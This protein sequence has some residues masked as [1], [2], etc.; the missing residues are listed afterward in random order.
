MLC[1]DTYYIYMF[2]WQFK[3]F[4][5]LV[6][7]QKLLTILVCKWHRVQTTPSRTT[8]NSTVRQPINPMNLDEVYAFFI[9]LPR[10]IHHSREKMTTATEV[11]T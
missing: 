9:I 4:Y 8:T 1:N 5:K 6:H 11:M 2:I 7:G 10:N 3:F